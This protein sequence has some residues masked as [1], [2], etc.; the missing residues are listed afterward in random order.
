MLRLYSR[1]LNDSV[2]CLDAGEAAPDNPDAIVYTREELKDLDG[3]AP[4]EIRAVHTLKK[5]FGGRYLG[6]QQK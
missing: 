3:R 5:R 6:A 4:D 1:L 2:I